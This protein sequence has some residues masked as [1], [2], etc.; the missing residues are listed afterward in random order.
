MP[1]D[2]F[3]IFGIDGEADA[4][5]LR[6][7]QGLEILSQIFLHLSGVFL[8][9]L[10]DEDVIVLGAR[11]ELGGK[12]Q[13][14]NAD[15]FLSYSV[16]NAGEVEGVGI[17]IE[18]RMFLVGID[19][20]E[21]EVTLKLDELDEAKYL[22]ETFIIVDAVLA[23]RPGFA[24]DLGAFDQ[25]ETLNLILN[26]FASHCDTVHTLHFLGSSWSMNF[27]A[28]IALPDDLSGGDVYT[29]FVEMRRVLEVEVGVDDSWGRDGRSSRMFGFEEATN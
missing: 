11:E 3:I 20:S 12:R 18:G 4:L 13:T 16:D 22:E 1:R 27:A 5:G 19:G 6:D 24:D 29:C 23:I 2:D 10:R 28:E 15:D 9:G 8:I 7:V 25:L 26:E 21:E 14:F 17:M